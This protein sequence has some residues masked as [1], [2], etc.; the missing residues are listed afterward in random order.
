MTSDIIEKYIRHHRDFEQGPK[1]L[2][3]KL[4]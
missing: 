3:L 2:N 4:R 1:Q